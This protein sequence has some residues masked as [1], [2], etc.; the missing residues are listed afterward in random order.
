MAGSGR[1]LVGY[2]VGEIM[3]GGKPR[4]GFGCEEMGDAWWMISGLC[5]PALGTI[6]VL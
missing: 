2:G 3:E 6:W 1:A 4:P 5:A